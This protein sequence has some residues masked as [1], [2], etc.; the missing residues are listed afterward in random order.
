MV[1]I[2]LP[3][4]LASR[5]YAYLREVVWYAQ[6]L[7]KGT[8]YAEYYA[9]RMN[10]IV[11]RNPDWGLNL[12]RLFQF[13]YLKT[14]GL[15][16]QSTL[17]DYGCGALAA[18]IHFIA[19]LELGKYVGLDISGEVL[20]EGERRLKRAGLKGRQPN[21]CLLDGDLV[22]VLGERKFDFL[23]AQSVLTHMP[24]DDIL[25]LLRDIRRHMHGRSQLFAGFAHTKGKPGQKQ[26]KDWYYNQ[27]FFIEAAA[28]H[29]FDVEFMSD[30]SH[31]D[32]PDGNDRMVRFT[33]KGGR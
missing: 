2:S 1:L 20:R 15:T 33:L 14:H 21:L 5:L 24:P 3:K 26:F 19:Y 4:R 18:G 6:H 23:W 13:E 11:T 27:D 31:P 32:D 9:N 17:L 28:A 16:P 29:G 10:R 30:W 8:S 25:T 7:A 22:A 12:D